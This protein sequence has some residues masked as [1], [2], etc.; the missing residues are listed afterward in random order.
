M[1]AFSPTSFVDLTY[2]G[3]TSL[4][5]D[6]LF[7]LGILVALARA[8]PALATAAGAAAA[9]GCWASSADSTFACINSC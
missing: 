9:A 1:P 6:A 7:E 8:L 3:P 4:S 5:D 2:V